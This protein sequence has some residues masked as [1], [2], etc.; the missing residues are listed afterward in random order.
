MSP[1]EPTS[2]PSEFWKSLEERQGTPEFRDYL[3]REFPREASV[4]ESS[5]SRRNFIEIMGASLAL[6]GLSAACSR[7]PME[8][9]VPYSEQPENLIPGKPT[10]FSSVLTMGGFAQGLLVE[11]HEGRPTKIEGNPN[12]PANLGGSDVFM[13]AALLSLYDPDRSTGVRKQNQASDWNQFLTETRANLPH[14]Q[15]TGGKGIYLLTEAISSPTLRDQIQIFLKN[16]PQSQ[17][18]SYD[19]G[20]RENLYR[21]SELALGERLEAI[22]RLDQAQVILSLDG[23][24]LDEGPARLR[25]ARQFADARRVRTGRE[26]MN[27]LYLAECTPSLTGAMADHRL[28]VKSAEI[29]NLA[30]EIARQVGVGIGTDKGAGAG[31]ETRAGT[32]IQ[33]VVQ[34][35]LAHRGR[36]LVICGEQQPP[37]VHALCLAMNSALGNFEKTIHFISPPV[38]EIPAPEKL[39]RAMQGGEVDTLFILGGNPVYN[40]PAD[41][42]FAAALRKVRMPIHLAEAVD[43]TSQICAW[44]L[45]QAHF[46]ETWGDAV[47]FDGTASIQQPVCAPFYGGKSA[48]ELLALLSDHPEKTAHMLIQDYWLK[49]TSKVKFSDPNFK[50]HWNNWLRD[51]LMADS[52]AK[53]RPARLRKFS[54][55]ANPSTK[56]G[57]EINFKLDPCIHDGRFANNGWLQELPKPLSKLTW[58]NAVFLAPETAGQLGLKTEDEVELS[59]RGRRVRGS[60]FIL[61]GHAVGAITVHLGY[62]RTQAGR[63]GNGQGFNAY[64]L[65]TSD[66]AFFSTGVTLKKTGQGVELATTQHHHSMEGRDLVRFGTQLQLVRDA[67]SIVPLRPNPEALIPDTP[68]P[69]AA[70]AMS[71]DLNACIGCNACM[72]ACQAEN[73]I[74]IVGRE[75]VRRGRS[76][77]WVRVDRYYQGS[78]EDPQIFFQPVPCMHCEAAPCEEVCPTV[79][80]SHSSEGLNQMTYN[81]CV[82]TRFCSNNCPYKVRRFN[83]FQYSDMKTSLA[84]MS[85]N[86]DVTV[87]SRG[88]MEKCSYCVQRIKGVQIQAELEDRKIRDG[89]IVTACEAACPTQA[90]LFGDRNDPQSRVARLKREPLN[91]A[92]LEELGTRPRTTYLAKL[93]NPNPR[94]GAGV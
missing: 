12:H 71:I 39:T 56:E 8:K 41:L 79:A 86:P 35:L 19:P 63:I 54:L 5:M 83:F 36:C 23:A 70:W 47:A 33:A 73:N 29:A 53:K 49:K 22:Y 15:K 2:N 17:W 28:A 68:Y 11:T 64:A 1:I 40:F 60:L 10:F 92:I 61:P 74:P 34:D 24:F 62:G 31:S 20:T 38:P 85:K 55:S 76:M 16:F 91:Y 75:E 3:H 88:V 66:A 82:G 59:H 84:K 21:G 90:I 30:R 89:E 18:H 45:P 52:A 25:L 87:R 14:W 48:L 65:Q 4:W 93:K 58:S 13:Q 26:Q 78:A 27:R 50:S 7:M 46:L 37:S 72:I 32:W 80:T 57:L 6:A 81:R 9:I 94:W 67:K 43:E 44:H 77:H 42:D 51:G 69:D